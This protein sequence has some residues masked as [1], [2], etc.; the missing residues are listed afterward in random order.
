[1]R[2]YGMRAEASKVAWSLVE[3]AT[4]FEYR[5][6]EVFAGFDRDHTDL[7]VPYPDALVP[8][9]WA[10]GAPLLGLR[11]ILGLDVVG[12]KLRSKPVLPEGVKRIRLRGVRVH[13][14]RLDAPR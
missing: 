10:A 3:A 8:Q 5:L 9:A 2:R 4:R 1:M 11:T 13:G 7:P 6:P 12:G 14:K